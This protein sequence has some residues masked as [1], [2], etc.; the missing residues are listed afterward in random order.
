MKESISIRNAITSDLEAVI[1]L[2]QLGPKEEKPA[3][4][5]GVFNHFVNSLEKDRH[6]LVA[7]S[8]NNV[9][10][11]IIGEVRAWEFGSPPCGWVFALAVSENVRAMGIGQLMFEEISRR[12]KTLGV[13]TVRTMADR[14]NKQLLS[15]FRGMGLRA[16]KYIELEMELN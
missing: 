7:E 11:F 3:Y 1:S 10:G 12:L 15:F 8:N 9:I 6:F 14:D 4:W 13:A 5:N 2:D 16:G